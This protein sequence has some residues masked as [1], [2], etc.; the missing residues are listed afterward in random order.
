[1]RSMPKE[2]GHAASAMDELNIL[3]NHQKEYLL[4][5]S[6]AKFTDGK[7]QELANA[8]GQLIFTGQFEWNKETVDYGI[9]D[10]VADSNQQLVIVQGLSAFSRFGVF[11]AADPEKLK[12]EGDRLSSGHGSVARDVVSLCD[13]SAVSPQ[14]DRTTWGPPAGVDGGYRAAI[15]QQTLK[16]IK[17]GYVSEEGWVI[18]PH[19][20]AGT[21]QERLTKNLTNVQVVSDLDSDQ[22]KVKST[23]YPLGI[24]PVTG[25]Q[26]YTTTFH[27]TSGDTVTVALGMRAHLAPKHQPHIALLNM[28]NAGTPGGAVDGAYA[29]AAQEEQLCF[30]SNLLPILKHHQ[31]LP[32]DAY[33]QEDEKQGLDSDVGYKNGG[34]QREPD[35]GSGIFSQ[36]VSFFRAPANIP[37]SPH[38]A[39][40]SSINQFGVIT[41]AA[42]SL[43]GGV[44]PAGYEKTMKDRIRFQLRSALLNGCYNIV[45]GAFG[46]GVFSNDPADVAKFYHDVFE[47]TEFKGKFLEV[48]FAVMVNNAK[49]QK[50]LDAFAAE[51]I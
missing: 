48:E 8:I 29:S 42:I 3:I 7:I 19:S 21:L 10:K 43:G 24:P 35:C 26:T 34:Q 2:K 37:G 46:C 40:S 51:F 32:D 20:D 50:N 12:S 6:S 28:A 22:G 13:L 9:S 31:K 11:T 27:V 1:M 39:R 45:L 41:S 49:D 14:T 47:E 16:S 38:Y 23:Y 33:S 4:S 44:K 30:R 17:G 15:M 18:L 36:N 25:T 5:K